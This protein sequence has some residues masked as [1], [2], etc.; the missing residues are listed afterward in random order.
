MSIVHSGTHNHLSGPDFFNAQVRIGKQLWA[1]NVEIHVNASDWYAHHHESDGNYDNV[2]LHVVWN[3]DVSVYRK[4]GT[5]I[6]TFELKDLIDPQLL[7]GYQKLM[8]G[9][10]GQFI[11]C[12]KDICEVSEFN[13][14]NWQDRLYLER[15]EEKSQVI[16]HLLEEFN[17]DWEKV[18]FTM[19]LKNFGSKI[20]GEAFFQLGK[21]LNFSQVR[22]LI[23]KPLELESLFFGMTGLLETDDILDSYYIELQNS[24]RYLSSKYDLGTFRSPKA[25]FFKL[26]PLNFPT[27][28][29]S[30]FAMLYSGSNNLFNE[31]V[32]CS[33]EEIYKRFRI[34]ASSYWDTHFNFGK[35]SKNSR[36]IVSKKFI[37]LLIINTLIPVRFCYFRSKGNY[38]SD[39]LLFLIQDI[40]EEKNSIIENF[41]LLGL[42][43]D[44]AFESQSLLQLYSNYCTKNKCLKCTVG[45]NLL[46]LKS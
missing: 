30:Q 24:Y 12:G 37:D 44:S 43:V 27:I 17:N 34:S 8:K 1:G 2:I 5:E 35:K 4:E 20:N 22:H 11:N 32:Y 29:L 36:K 16:I 6:P 45:T 25:S 9:N 19:L 41:K 13:F 38:N 14:K 21:D 39:S 33:T 42:S 31:L 40:K 28:R 10:D 18:L 7:N 15:L 3:D 26:R 46:N 23:G